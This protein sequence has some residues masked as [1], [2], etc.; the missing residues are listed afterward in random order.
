MHTSWTNKV[1]LRR[2]RLSDAGALARL[3]DQLG[4]P[5]TAAALRRRLT[6]VLTKSSH[7]VFV[8]ETDS[9]GGWI[10]VSIVNSLESDPFAEIRGLVISKTLRR[11]GIGS[12][13]VQLAE[14]WARTKRCPKIRVRTNIT[15]LDARLFYKRL[16]FRSQKRQE[17]FDKM[18]SAGGQTGRSSRRTNRRRQSHP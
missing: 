6:S 1:R 15:R 16:G 10:H 5:S 2:A 4:Y 3:S 12:Q 7:A 17:V 11:S 9:I 18:P 8:A 13:L 14:Q